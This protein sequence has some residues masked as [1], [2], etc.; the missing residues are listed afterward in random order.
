[1]GEILVAPDFNPGGKKGRKTRP[2]NIEEK[3]TNFSSDGM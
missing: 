3:S 2:L 1:M